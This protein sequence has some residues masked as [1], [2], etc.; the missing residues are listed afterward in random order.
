MKLKIILVNKNLAY[1]LQD[2]AK[3]QTMYHDFVLAKGPVWKPNLP[4]SGDKKDFGSQQ[5]IVAL[6]KFV[7]DSHEKSFNTIFIILTT[8]RWLQ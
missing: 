5:D 2:N 7:N 4:A 3:A 8:T 1:R 6:E